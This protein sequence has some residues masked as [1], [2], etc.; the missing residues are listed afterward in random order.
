MEGIGY[1]SIVIS[2]WGVWIARREMLLVA[3]CRLLVV[4]VTRRDA[5][6]LNQD[7]Q[8]FRMGKIMRG[9]RRSVEKG[10]GD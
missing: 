4:R 1:W 9:V 10:L 3:S 8:D 5:Y 7:L 6:C 2:Q